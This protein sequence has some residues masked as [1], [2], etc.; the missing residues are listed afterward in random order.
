MLCTHPCSD[1]VSVSGVLCAVVIS[2]EQGLTEGVVD[3]PLTVRR[4]RT[5]LPTAVST[6]VGY[7]HR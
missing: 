2:V 6:T 7:I 1:G 5:Q 4:I 3:I